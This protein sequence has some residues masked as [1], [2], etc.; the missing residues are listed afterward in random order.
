MT[1]QTQIKDVRPLL[2]DE[3]LE[4]KRQIGPLE[5]RIEKVKGLLKDIVLKG[6]PY[7]DEDRGVVL[8]LQDRN[9]T[10]YDLD[11]LRKHFPNVA[12]GV[13]VEQVDPDRMKQ[14]IALGEVTESELDAEGIRIRSTYARALIVE[15]LKGMRR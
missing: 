7:T 12:R 6:G 10:E 5:D 1:D 13:I 2:L 4:L 14:A 15:P 8:R 11:G 9:R 3:Y